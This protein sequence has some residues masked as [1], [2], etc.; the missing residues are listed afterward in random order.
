L[1]V[2]VCY[3]KNSPNAV[4]ACDAFCEGV[5]AAGDYYVKIFNEKGLRNLSECDASVQVCDYNKHCGID[6]RYHLNRI[7]KLTKTRRIIIDTG[8]VKNK[9][10]DD[11]DLDRYMQIG[12]DG[13]KR[14]AKCYAEDSS[15][16]RWAALE[17]SEKPWRHNGEHILII[18]QH[19][20]GIST[21]HLDIIQ[22]WEEIIQEIK[23][24]T[25]SPIKFRPHP[26][27]KKFPKGMYQVTH[28][29]TIEE[30]LEKCWCAVARTTNGAVD[31]II[32]GI[33]V[34]TPDEG[35]MAYDVASHDIKDIL[36]PTT[37]D[38]TNWLAQLG[39]SQWTI[40]EMQ[41]GLPWKHLRRFI[42]E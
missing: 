37:P 19:E 26:N 39:Y 1:L 6:F 30:D 3:T 27:Q 25:N 32:N 41:E 11:N 34:I 36:Y 4:A 38:R 22:W 28:D 15:L 17:F 10:C 12:Y 2:G 9:R 24:V 31:A 33:P 42:N 16:D 20:I 13:I 21:Q 29:T 40:R 5:E 18:G 7:S 8:F 35:C 23:S 14:H